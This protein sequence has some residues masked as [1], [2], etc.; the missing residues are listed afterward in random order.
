MSKVV[1]NEGEEFCSVCNGESYAPLPDKD[2]E[3]L[4]REIC[5]K[6]KGAGKLDW[7]SNAMFSKSD[8]LITNGMTGL[9]IAP[10]IP[11]HD[12]TFNIHNKEMIKIAE[13]GFY[14]EG[15]KVSGDKEIYEGFK[16]FL[17]EAG[18]Y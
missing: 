6:C 9:T 13:D 7:I 5:W 18:Y 12:V 14:V 10:Y 8:S 16:K 4:S 15:R 3:T 11:T 17:G 2:K 1:L